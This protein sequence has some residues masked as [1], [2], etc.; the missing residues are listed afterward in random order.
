[1]QYGEDPALKDKIKGLAVP[2]KL[3]VDRGG[4]SQINA[5]NICDVINRT[6]FWRW[7]LR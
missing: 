6:D 4:W 5:G 2:A 1:M 7:D 3:V